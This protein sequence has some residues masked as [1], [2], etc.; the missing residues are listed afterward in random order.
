MSWASLNASVN[1]SKKKIPKAVL[2]EALAAG[3]VA[4]TTTTGIEAN[5]LT[6]PPELNIVELRTREDLAATAA[7]IRE[8]ANNAAAQSVE[9]LNSIVADFHT[10]EKNESKDG[11][12]EKEGGGEEEDELEGTLTIEPEKDEKESDEMSEETVIAM[13]AVVA[14]LQQLKEQKRQEE[15]DQPGSTTGVGRGRPR[16]SRKEKVTI[17]KG[18]HD[19]QQQRQENMQKL[20]ERLREKIDEKSHARPQL[21]SLSKQLQKPPKQGKQGKPGATHPLWTKP[22]TAAEMEAESIRYWKYMDAQN[23]K[24]IAHHGAEEFPFTGSVLSSVERASATIIKA[25]WA[26]FTD[27][28]LASN[29]KDPEWAKRSLQCLVPMG[30]R[31]TKVSDNELKAMIVAFAPKAQTVMGGGASAVPARV[32]EVIAWLAHELDL[33]SVNSISCWRVL[34]ELHEK[35]RGMSNR[36]QWAHAVELRNGFVHKALI[37]LRNRY[38]YKTPEELNAAVEAEKVAADQAADKKSG[39]TAE[40]RKEARKKLADNI[41]AAFAKEDEEDAAAAEAGDGKETGETVESTESIPTTTASHRGAIVSDGVVLDEST[42][43]AKWFQDRA[44]KRAAYARRKSKRHGWRQVFDNE[45]DR[46]AKLLTARE[47]VAAGEEGK[48][49]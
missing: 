10:D 22:M 5:Y 29:S 23:A 14:K 3:A 18:K 42:T 15:L 43:T 16:E 17:D 30:R 47:E 36:T 26:A 2:A 11:V 40:Q 46:V 13:R 7:Q 49:D 33:L 44:E 32:F 27:G 48:Q 39:T 9:L 1:D 19:K 20:S 8:D 45:T 41:L 38:K 4:P 37:L 6:T 31:P 25:A 21:H 24:I 28:L 35:C 12:A 34:R